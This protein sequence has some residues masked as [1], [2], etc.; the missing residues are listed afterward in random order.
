MK[1]AD[2]PRQNFIQFQ[3]PEDIELPPKCL[4]HEQTI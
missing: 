1:V 3:L 4:R 2:L